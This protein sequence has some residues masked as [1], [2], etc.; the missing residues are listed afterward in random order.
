MQLSP[1]NS[2][3]CSLTL[4]EQLLKPTFF[5]SIE[6]ELK[7]NP[8]SG[9]ACR[10]DIE[11]K[12]A[13]C[14]IRTKNLIPSYK[15][16][17]PQLRCKTKK[18]CCLIAWSPYVDG[19]RYCLHFTKIKTLTIYIHCSMPIWVKTI[20]DLRVQKTSDNLFDFITIL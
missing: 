12:T 4:T 13:A 15:Q 6:I 10:D 17:G 5:T 18:F 1:Y 7:Q 9:P 2:A 14:C 16:G 8:V 3:F 19:W 11:P 20:S